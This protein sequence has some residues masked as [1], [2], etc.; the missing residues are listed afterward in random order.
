MFSL[1]RIIYAKAVYPNMWKIHGAGISGSYLFNRLKNEGIE[2][3]ISD[4]KISNFYIPCGFATNRKR[5]KP[6]LEK[7]GIDME[8]IQTSSD[9]RVTIEGNNFPPLVLDSTDICTI[10][11]MMFEALL[12]QGIEPEKKTDVTGSDYHVDATGISRS[13]L[14]APA[15]DK[16]MFAIE[17][18]CDRSPYD[19]FYFYFFPKGRGYFWSFPVGDHFHIGAGG[20]DLMEV[21]GSLSSFQGLRLLSRN[22][23]MG[24]IMENIHYG[25]VVGIGESIGYISPLLGEGIIP[26]LES[27]EMLASSILKGNSFEEILMDYEKQVN[28]SLRKFQK[29]ATLVEN[30]QASKVMTMENIGALRLALSE[31][32][33]FGINIK[34]TKVLRH[35]L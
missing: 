13:L 14:P 7:S 21:R 34:L 29:L 23:R 26:G 28:V 17:K 9:E 3:S 2:V 35:F 32:K 16:R 20:I 30:I 1:R 18:V 24:P 33:N 22:I 11:K 15:R 4:P 31:A 6:Y 10:D 27:A 19:N 5:I 25:N 8:G 12:L